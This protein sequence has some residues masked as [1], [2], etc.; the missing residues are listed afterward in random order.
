M[1]SLLPVGTVVDL[2]TR[3]VHVLERMNKLCFFHTHSHTVTRQACKAS[4]THSSRRRALDLPVHVCSAQRSAV[5]TTVLEFVLLV[6]E[7]PG[8]T[9]RYLHVHVCTTS[10][11]CKLNFGCFVVLLLLGISFFTSAACSCCRR[12]LLECFSVWL[13]EKICRAWIQHSSCS[14]LSPLSTPVE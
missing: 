8:S 14:V 6:I 1:Y 13:E 9:C 5:V 4:H 3:L 12:R 7:I 11:L 10:L 2:A